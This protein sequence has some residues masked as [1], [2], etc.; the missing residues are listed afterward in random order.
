[1]HADEIPTD[2]GLVE[3]LIATQFPQ[4]AELPIRP[5]ASAGTDNALYRL[6]ADMVVRLPRI[7]G[8]VKSMD[9]EQ[10]WLPH[11]APLLPVAIPEPLG[12]GGPGQGYPWPW[13][14]LRWLDG[15]P[16]AVDRLADP[17]RLARDLA[18]FIG[19]LRRLDTAGAPPAG[20]RGPLAP[21]DAQTREAIAALS[22]M[23][24]TDAV[25]AAWDAALQVPEWQGAPVWLHTDI[26]PGNVLVAGGRLSAV[27]DW[28]GAGVGD[29][30]CDLPIAWN[31]L[32]AGVRD[33]FRETL[34]VDDETWARGRGW[35]LSMR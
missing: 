8:A 17:E 29:P 30:A 9:A 20:R 19:A 27:I 26:S 32:P 14:V 10:R 23:V 24:D 16:P 3:R 15:E 11:L 21:R 2:R 28:A 22:G 35:A 25:T 34:D 5:V 4:W 1:M 33:L 18:A 31:L 13:S 12:R 7:A 6:G